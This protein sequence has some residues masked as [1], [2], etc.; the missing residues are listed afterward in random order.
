MTRHTLKLQKPTEIFIE[1]PIPEP[2]SSQ[3]PESG[4][5]HLRDIIHQVETRPPGPMMDEESSKFSVRQKTVDEAVAQG[6][7]K[8][9][10]VV[11]LYTNSRAG[12]KYLSINWGTIIGHKRHIDSLNETFFHPLIVK[13]W[14]DNTETYEHPKELL[15]VNPCPDEGQVQERIVRLYNLHQTQT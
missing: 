11:P 2:E 3:Q 12:A 10:V 8:G 5:K 13:W 9:A 4:F 7:N 1:N 6:W 15:L 14:K